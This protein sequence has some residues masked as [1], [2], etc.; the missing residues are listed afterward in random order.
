MNVLLDGADATILDGPRGRRWIGRVA[1]RAMRLVGW[2]VVLVEAIPRRCVV[3]VYPHTSNWDLALGLMAKWIMDLEFHVIVKDSAFVGPLGRILTR[4]GG[5]PIDRRA[6]TGVVAALAERF[7]EQDVLR[8]VIAPEGTR[9]R[10]AHWKSGFYN[11]AREADVPIALSF[12]DY[13]RRETGV[14]AWFTPSGDRDADMQAIAR[15]YAGKVA[16][17]PSQAG[18]VQ[19][20]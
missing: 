17:H 14:G 18:P 1:W 11:I 19:L 4:L 13:A 10:T 15:F 7:R 8:L 2:R 6:P 5:I 12:V 9:S 16:K 3:V 20:G